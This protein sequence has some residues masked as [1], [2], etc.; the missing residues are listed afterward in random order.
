LIFPS[1]LQTCRFPILCTASPPLS[2]NRP[3]Y[4][5]D[6]FSLVALAADDKATHS[7]FFFDFDDTLHLTVPAARAAYQH[8][9]AKSLHRL[10]DAL[11]RDG[12][13]FHGEDPLPHPA[14]PSLLR[15]L[16]HRHHHVL[17]LSAGSAAQLV[18]S[19]PLTLQSL[20]PSPYLT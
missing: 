9:N 6:I 17:I 15:C 3:L 12:I 16:K 2:P 13:P 10:S 11:H 5:G 1:W 20:S 4:A 19:P 14:V 18:P 8:L 7:F